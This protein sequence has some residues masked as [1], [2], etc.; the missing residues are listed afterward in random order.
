MAARRSSV[1]RI[2]WEQTIDT[3]LRPIPQ[4]GRELRPSAKPRVI[5]DNR[6]QFIARDF[7]EFVRVA[8]MTHVRT[9]PYDLKSNGELERWHRTIKT[10]VI[11]RA[12]PASVEEA[13]KIVAASV[14][15]YNDRRLHSAIGFVTPADALCSHHAEIWAARDGSSKPRARRTELSGPTETRRSIR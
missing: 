3:T 12:P 10:D 8:G 14:H 2:G 7:K 9:S 4:R 1:G 11:R 13:R 15:H 5:S 6:P